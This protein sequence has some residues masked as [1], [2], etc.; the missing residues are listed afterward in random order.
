LSNIKPLTTSS[1]II[2]TFERECQLIPLSVIICCSFCNELVFSLLNLSASLPLSL[3]HA[4]LLLFCSD[5]GMSANSIIR[6]YLL[7]TPF[8]YLPSNLFT[9]AFFSFVLTPINKNI[10]FSS[11]DF[12]FFLFCLLLTGKKF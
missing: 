11:V 3:V 6:H 1:V 9:H 5:P 7:F 10:L 8:L 12:L 4:R 2:G